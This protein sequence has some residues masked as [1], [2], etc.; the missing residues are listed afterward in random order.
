MFFGH[1]SV[2]MNILGGIPAVFAEHGVAAPAIA[3]GRTAPPGGDGFVQHATI[4]ENVKPLSK[5]EDF[6]AAIRAGVGEQVDVALMKLC[7]VDIEP[8]TDVDSV[9]A[10]YSSTM[11]ALERDFPDV[12]FVKV[13]VP[14]TTEPGGVS[15]LKDR[16][17]G[18]GSP[19]AAANTAR[20]R[21][22]DR[23]RTEYAGDHLFDLAAV[24]STTPDGSRVG[25]T[26]QGTTY[27]SLYSGYASDDGHLNEEGSRRA[28]GAWL[29]AVA[30]ASAK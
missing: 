11:A 19:G 25:G 28:A 5:I 7:Y 9:F 3:E 29:A 26:Y 4:G 22:N 30:G 14:L 18:Q 15:K 27:F 10:A 21:F 23:I 2:G 6:D 1:Q 16:V 20:Q 17:S 12:T 24:E 8:K 13:T